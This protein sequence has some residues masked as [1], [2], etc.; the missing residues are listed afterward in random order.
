[1]IKM[2]NHFGIN[3]ESLDDE[4]LSYFD[5]TSLE[6]DCDSN[7]Q[8]DN[9][10]DIFEDDNYIDFEE[11]NCEEKSYLNTAKRKNKND[12]CDEELEKYFNNSGKDCVEYGLKSLKEDIIVCT[13][14]E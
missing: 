8:I 9:Y 3:N 10:I 11:T 14:Y 5:F 12:D 6:F 7:S 1:M 13:K 2:L 4:K